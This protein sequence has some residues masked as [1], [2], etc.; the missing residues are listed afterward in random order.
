[1]FPVSMYLTL[2][3]NSGCSPWTPITITAKSGLKQEMK[4]NE[5][6]SL[7]RREEVESLGD[8]RESTPW[9]KGTASGQLESGANCIKRAGIDLRSAGRA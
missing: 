1:M 7:Y 9:Y 2:S 8:A 3:R 6:S 5:V 4:D